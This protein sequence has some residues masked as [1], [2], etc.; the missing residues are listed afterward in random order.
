M[1]DRQIF[2]LIARALGLS[3]F[4]YGFLVMNTGIL[5]WIDP[6]A[7]Y[8]HSIAGD[9]FYGLIMMFLGAV[10]VGWT[11]WLVAFSYRRRSA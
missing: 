5:R 3:V 10:L 6:R 11:E 9:V 8:R 4:I 2:G 7:S 1:S